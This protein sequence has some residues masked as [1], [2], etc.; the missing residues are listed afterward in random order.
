MIYEFYERHKKTILTLG[1]FFA[2]FMLFMYGINS[3]PLIDVDETRYVSM[4]K[5]MLERKSWY[6]LYFNNNYFFEK[7]PLYFW[8]IALS[9][10]IFGSI[11]E[12]TARFFISLIALFGVYATYLFVKKAVSNRLAIISS[13]IFSTSLFYL[14]LSHVAML[15]IILTVFIMCSIFSGYVTLFVK[16]KNKKY[17]WW[18]AYLFSGLAVMTKGIP[19]VA[20]P[21]MSL[22]FGFLALGKAKE[23][24]KPL[25][26]I[27]G[28][29]IFFA[30][31]L[32]WHWLM[33]KMH[34]SLF[35]KE[36]II[37]HHIARFV[38]S[39][40]L[41]RKQ[42]FWFYIPILFAAIFPW[43]FVLIS[44]ILKSFKGFAKKVKRRFKHNFFIERSN[45]D[46]ITILMWAYI[47]VTFFF[48]SFASTKLPTYMLPIIA[49]FAILLGGYWEQYLWENKN[50]KGMTNANYAFA[51]FLILASVVMLA[52]PS[53]IDVSI[54]N[55]IKQMNIFVMTFLMLI[56][57]LMFYFNKNQEREAV[58]C[59]Y[60]AFMIISIFVCVKDVTKII[61]G[62]GQDQL[63]DYAKYVSKMPE[64]K[65]FTYNFGV[66]PSVAFYF[67]KNVTFL[68]EIDDTVKTNLENEL[69]SNTPVYVIVK[70]ITYNNDLQ[71]TRVVKKGPKYTLLSN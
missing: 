16:D 65:L 36:Y 25:H 4:A 22:F 31:I 42:P 14:L 53:Y 18:L 9:F 38:N 35:L 10:K 29:I 23:L 45:F 3:Y 2:L 44:Y 70:N 21:A 58:F 69:S 37:K 26:I 71:N 12:F 1:G 67:G 28:V 62:A 34:G 19:G 11:S 20:I 39:Q 47:F 6:T 61:T 68:P 41:G 13:A 52:A 8:V 24:F 33:L 43:S 50:N 59:I 48:Y 15:D 55:Y 60:I 32:P 66:R 46:I 17:F 56:S 63:M 64:A 49:P 27:P 57:G 40:D 7:P 30:I 51:F 54:A 5:E